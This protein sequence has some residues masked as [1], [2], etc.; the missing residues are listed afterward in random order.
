VITDVAYVAMHSSPLIQP[1]SGDAGGM[2]IYLDRLSRTM[3]DRGINVTTFTRRTSV[4]N[5]TVVEVSDRY[6]VVHIEAGP[7]GWMS[8]A[9]MKPYTPEFTAGVTNW[10]DENR[11]SFDLVHSHYWLSGRTGVDVK[12]KYAIPLANSF[13][14]LG[15]VKDRTRGPNERPSSAERLITEKEIIDQ[16]DCIITSTPYEFEDLLEHYGANPERLCINPPGVDH[17]VFNQGDRAVARHHLGLGEE[18]IILYAGRIQAHKG[19][20]VAVEA[21]AMLRSQLEPSLGVPRLLIVGGASGD[22]GDAELEECRSIAV[23]SGVNDGI[24]LVPPVSHELLAEY[25]R[26]ADL[27][28]V[29]SRSESFGLVAVE[30]QAC[31]TPVVAANIGG[32]SYVVSS[33]ESGLLVDH[34]VP[35]AFCT[36]MKAIL[37]HPEFARQLSQG[38][39]AFAQR[40]SWD[41]AATHLIELYQGI[42]DRGGDG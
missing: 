5:P 10:I 8:L 31:G 38:A 17:R 4:I 24:D 20:S 29:P 36:A 9:D 27:V 16:S 39:V 6:R 28:I 35:E 1:G 40:F 12:N 7:L 42:T 25:Y 30:A 11:A 2:N 26:A 14:T 37:R 21:Y 41:K 13:H 19:T 32:L 33:S 18:P 15:K 23:R 22:D 3:A 34:H